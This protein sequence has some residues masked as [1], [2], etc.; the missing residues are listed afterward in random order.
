MNRAAESAASLRARAVVRHQNTRKMASDREIYRPDV[1]LM[2]KQL[3]EKK[4]E[5]RPEL[6]LM[7]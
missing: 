5:G 7:R 2:R 1:G 3:L 4:F 6:R